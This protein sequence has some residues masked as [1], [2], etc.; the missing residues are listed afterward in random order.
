[1]QIVIGVIEAGTETRQ[2]SGNFLHPII[3][4]DSNNVQDEVT[5][6]FAMQ[7]AQNKLSVLPFKIQFNRTGKIG[8]LKKLL[9]LRHTAFIKK[10]LKRTS[11]SKH[12]SGVL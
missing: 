4:R 10:C 11:I 8:R 9:C 1:K 5:V 7:D 3:F 12:F 6:L 2:L